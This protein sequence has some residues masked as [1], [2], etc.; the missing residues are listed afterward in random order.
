[1]RVSVRSGDDRFVNPGLDR[2]AAGEADPFDVSVRRER[3]LG[4]A[5][6]SDEASFVS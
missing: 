2:L 6:S 1:M 3:P 4:R 5:L